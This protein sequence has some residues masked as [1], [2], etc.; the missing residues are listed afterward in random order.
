MSGRQGTGHGAADARWERD[1]AFTLRTRDVSGAAI[2]AVLAEVRAHCAESG[3]RPQE[4][5]GEPVPYA[6]ALTF[7]PQARVEGLS[8]RGLVLVLV[9]VACLWVVPGALGALLRGVDLRLSWGSLV[10]AGVALGAGL[11][12][13]WL[14]TLGFRHPRLLAP[15]MTVGACAVVL[16]A[17]LLP[18]SAVVVDPLLPAVV[19][20]LVLLGSVAALVVGAWRAPQDGIVDPLAATRPPSRGALWAMRV[21]PVAIVVAAGLLTALDVLSA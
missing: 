7:G 18:G 5:F 6:E 11:L 3:E 17:L 16:P 4:A 19:G 1:V 13:P 9:S 20:S 2:G 10:T 14:L 21:S 15:V 12:S 8:T